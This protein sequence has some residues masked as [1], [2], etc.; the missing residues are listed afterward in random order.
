MSD[1]SSQNTNTHNS[2]SNSSSEEER[3]GKKKAF[4]FQDDDFLIEDL[5][6]DYK[7]LL[8]GWHISLN[9]NEINKYQP[10]IDTLKNK[11]VTFAKIQ[12]S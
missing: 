4:D 8:D 10:L 12:E 3:D 11:F 7:M 6:G 2:S 5:E 9:K 1:H